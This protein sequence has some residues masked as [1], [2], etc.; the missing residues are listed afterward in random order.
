MKACT[1]NGFNV[2]LKPGGALKTFHGYAVIIKGAWNPHC[3]SMREVLQNSHTSPKLNFVF[4][5]DPVSLRY[6]LLRQV[7]GNSW[8]PADV[9]GTLE[10]VKFGGPK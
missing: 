8:G 7:S 1:D 6:P 2:I 10:N 4:M 3:G 5:S 9:R